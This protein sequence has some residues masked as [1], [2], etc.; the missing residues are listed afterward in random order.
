[1]DP[2]LSL[3]LPAI[4][5]IIGGL[6]FPGGAVRINTRALRGR[7]WES[8]VSAAGPAMT[9]LVM[10]LFGLIVSLGARSQYGADAFYL[11]ASFICFLQATALI[12]NLLPIPGLDG[13]GIIRPYLPPAIQRRSMQIAGTGTMLVLM[14]IF[15]LPGGSDWIV[16]AGR[17]LVGWIGVPASFVIRGYRDFAFWL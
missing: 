1:M 6:A 9:A 10:V 8:V 11:A 15:F 4:F 16:I 14:A 5:V 3:V 7:I 12:L 2:F 13:F 17:A